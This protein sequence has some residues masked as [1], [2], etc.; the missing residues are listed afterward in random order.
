[1]TW[2]RKLVFF[3][4]CTLIFSPLALAAQSTAPETIAQTLKTFVGTP[5]I[6]GY[7]R[8]LAAEIRSRLQAF[9]PETDSLGDVIITLGRAAAPGRCGADG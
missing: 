3:F 2:L 7:E 1:M 6:P 8:A 4:A 5:A 9:S